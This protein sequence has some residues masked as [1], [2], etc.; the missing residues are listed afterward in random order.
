MHST[1]HRSQNAWS[2]VSG[3]CHFPASASSFD[4]HCPLRI[5]HFQKASLT[6]PTLEISYSLPGIYGAFS[7]YQSL[8]I[9]SFR[10]SALGHPLVLVLP[11]HGLGLP[12][13]PCLGLLRVGTLLL[14][15]QPDHASIR[16]TTNRATRCG[17][18][19]SGYTLG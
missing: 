15:L 3:S 11:L 8:P 18:R 2:R 7:S 1:L 6:P 16:S 5:S 17:K 9:L 10:S 12:A 13:T 14:G 4:F 19:I